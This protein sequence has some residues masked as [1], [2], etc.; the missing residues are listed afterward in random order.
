M[1]KIEFFASSNQ[2]EENCPVKLI[3][4]SNKDMDYLREHLVMG[5]PT[6]FSNYPNG[7]V[8]LHPEP[9]HD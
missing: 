6:R 1:L 3:E 8:K 9:E 4:I 5:I 7:I 2:I